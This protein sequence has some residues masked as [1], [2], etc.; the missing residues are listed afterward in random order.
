[1]PLIIGLDN[2]GDVSVIIDG[3][4]VVYKDGKG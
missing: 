4:H 3:A 2:K 1:M